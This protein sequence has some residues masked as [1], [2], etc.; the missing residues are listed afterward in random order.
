VASLATM[1]HAAERE[2]KRLGLDM[3][4]RVVWSGTAFERQDGKVCRLKRK[5]HRA[6]AHCYEK[7][8]L[9]GTICV[10]RGLG[11]GWAETIKHEVAHFAPGGRGHGIGFLKTRAAQ[12]S[13]AAKAALRRAGKLRCSRHQWE[14][15]SDVLA[16]EITGR[17][18]VVTYRAYCR[19]CGQW[20][21]KR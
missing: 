13:K 14:P 4:L 10:R 19:S 15:T 9:Y 11:K 16:S 12:G 1:Q 18:L 20:R 5:Y 21:P 7:T 3:P 2:A 8:P 6:H 17:G